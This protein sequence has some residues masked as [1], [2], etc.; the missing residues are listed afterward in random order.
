MPGSV[1][2]NKAKSDRPTKDDIT[3]DRGAGDLPNSDLAR[4]VVTNPESEGQLNLAMLQ[5]DHAL[6]S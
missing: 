4:K 5:A 6:E 1:T 3:T 2:Q